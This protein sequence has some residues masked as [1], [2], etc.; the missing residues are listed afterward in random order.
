VTFKLP[1]QVVVAWN[2][3]F[4]SDS[5]TIQT[6]TDGI[7]SRHINILMMQIQVMIQYYGIKQKTEKM[8]GIFYHYLYMV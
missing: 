8:I 7:I 3:T 6:L 5:K 1:L 4:L 2:K